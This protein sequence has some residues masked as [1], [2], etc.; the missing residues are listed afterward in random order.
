[1][2][3]AGRSYGVGALIALIVLVL[4][5]VFLATGGDWKVWGCIAALAVARLV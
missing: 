4:A 5:I 2:N 3:F 1:M